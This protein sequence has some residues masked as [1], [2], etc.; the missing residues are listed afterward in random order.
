MRGFTRVF[1]KH[2]KKALTAGFW[3]QSHNEG[4][5]KI[6]KRITV[7]NISVGIGGTRPLFCNCNV[8]LDAYVF[9]FLSARCF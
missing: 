5:L 3:N 1:Y 8:A 6:A 7:V 2:F 9:S 4:E